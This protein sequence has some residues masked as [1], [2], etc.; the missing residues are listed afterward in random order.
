MNLDEHSFISAHKS[1]LHDHP[2]GVSAV[3]FPESERLMLHE[4]GT[5]LL[6]FRPG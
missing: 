1:S 5:T 6:H 4:K 2:A 3:S